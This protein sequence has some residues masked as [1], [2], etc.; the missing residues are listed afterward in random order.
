MAGDQVHVL[1]ALD[2]AKTQWYHFTAIVVAGMGFFTDAYDL[3]CISLVTKLIGRV[4]Y[5]VPGSPHPG[6]LPPT[7]AAAVNGVAFVGTLSGQLFFGWLGDKV[8]RKSVYGMTLL[9]MIICSVASGLSFSHTPTTVMATLC[10]FRF[11][12]GF[13]IGGDYPLSAT[14]MSEYAN[15]RTRGAFIAAVFSMQGFGILASS[16]VTMVV[17]AAFDR[18]TGHPAPLDT[19]EAADIAWR[20]ILMV[21]AVPAALTFYWRMAMPETARYVV[22]RVLTLSDAPISLT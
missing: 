2:G 7:V 21:G 12:L 11:W 13:G 5:T 6:S 3:F 17:A 8:G 20:V 10:F 16:G 14:I 1:S 15:K 19:P 22:L 9:L 4:Y 18:F